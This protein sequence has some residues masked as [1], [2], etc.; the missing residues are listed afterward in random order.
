MCGLAA[1]M[2]L[3]FC[4]AGS[5]P[6]E[7]FTPQGAMQADLNA[8]GHSLTNAGTVQATTVAAA[9]VSAS[10]GV[11]G[12]QSYLLYAGFH[13]P[14][15]SLQLA[16]S[17]DGKN[18]DRLQSNVFNLPSGN[19][20]RD[21]NI[22]TQPNDPYR[23]PLKVG[24]WYWLAHT[25]GNFGQ[26][27]Y[28]T[29]EKSH[30]L[31]N[32]YWVENATFTGVSGTINNVWSPDWY[33]PDGVN[34]YILFQ[35]SNQAGNSYGSPGI[36][37]VPVTN[38]SAW[39]GGTAPSFGSY[40]NLGLPSGA[41]GPFGPMLVGSTYYLFFDNGGNDHYAT[42][43]SPLSGYTDQGVVA[44]HFPS[45]AG[46]NIESAQMVQISPTLWRFYFA[47]T[48]S[49]LV[50]YSEA[51]AI[52]G[53]TWSAAQ[54]IVYLDGSGLCAGCPVTLTNYDDIFNAL[55]A[56]ASPIPYASDNGTAVLSPPDGLLALFTGGNN[57]GNGNASGVRSFDISEYGNIAY[58]QNGAFGLKVQ[59]SANNNVALLELG[60]SAAATGLKNWTLAEYYADGELQFFPANDNDTVP[61][62]WAM[63]LQRNGLLRLLNNVQLDGSGLQSLTT[64][65]TD[66]SGNII[67]TAAQAANKV[68]AG[69]TSGSATPTFRSLVPGDLSWLGTGVGSALGNA[70]NGA[71]G[72][73]VLDSNGILTINAV[74][75][76][77]VNLLKLVN[78]NNSAGFLVGAALDSS[79]D[80]GT[81]FFTYAGAG[82]N[83]NYVGMG[84]PGKVYGV[85][86]YASGRGGIWGGS[87][88]S[89][90]GSSG[91]YVQ[92][93][94]I[95]TPNLVIANGFTNTGTLTGFP[96]VHVVSGTLSSGSATVTVPSGVTPWVQDTNSSTTNVGAITVTV[97][98]T[99][100]T[101]KSTT[102]SD[103]STFNLFYWQ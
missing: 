67:P 22:L 14:D 76:S 17:R 81:F 54:Q 99:T 6:V 41:N 103:G 88:P 35:V 102:A 43:S 1:G 25:S 29:L 33:T 52:S 84:I 71:G 9:T 66:S 36:G 38:V 60:N 34:F 85:L 72:L 73:T 39:Q 16:G 37:Y 27:A 87:A 95:K 50:Y 10:A 90:D 79:G 12:A 53:A 56:Q 48:G 96:S 55:A 64:V 19:C 18:L 7:N 75:S 82:S 45:E 2:V 23:R 61:A 58:L 65:G 83:S 49:G 74:S 80:D 32:W 8:G 92:S 13:G 62:N 24:G 97:S 11:T 63:T 78:A 3:L 4:G 5:V 68:Y 69:P 46:G 94:N 101:V 44:S 70:V 26:C 91:W 100:A 98:G 15:N 30:D 42:S 59:A 51:A 93:G 47:N 21:D 31:K 28:F 86:Q 89:D 77:D 57:T 40:V 20:M